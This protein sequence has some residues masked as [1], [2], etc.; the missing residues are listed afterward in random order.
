MQRKYSLQTE[1]VRKYVE[2]SQ[3]NGQN[4]CFVFGKS[5]V[6]NILETSNSDRGFSWFSLVSP[7]SAMVVS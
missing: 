1:Y 6:Q 5:Q 2:V 4:S 3:L 7:V